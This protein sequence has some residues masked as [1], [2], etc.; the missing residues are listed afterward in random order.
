[1]E[2]EILPYCEEHDIGVIMYSPMASGLLSGSFT[3]ERLASMREDDWRRSEADFT[4]PLVSRSLALVD[5]LTLVAER[6]GC[7]MGEL[8]IAWALAHPAV[9]GAIVGL[10][11][12]AQVD[13]LLGA[14]TVELN[15]DDLDEIAAM[16]EDA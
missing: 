11:R 1:V 5:R 4:E 13:L 15:R 10:R 6:K 9:D 2:A 16:I 12:P 14:A 8:A 3:R 7:S